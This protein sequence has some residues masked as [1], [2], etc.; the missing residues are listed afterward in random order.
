MLTT[1]L[2]ALCALSLSITSV[3]ARTDTTDRYL[4]DGNVITN[5]DGSQLAG[6]T[7]LEYIIQSGY[8][9]QNVVRVHNI[10]TSDYQHPVGDEVKVIGIGSFS[11]EPTIRIRATSGVDVDRDIVYVIDG[12]VISREEFI[13]IN[14]SDIASME[15]IKETANEIRKKYTDRD[16]VGVLIITT[17]KQI[18]KKATNK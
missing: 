17:K 3:S 10:T 2:S 12:R 5:F 7:I 14:P 15:V 16:D 11:G 13:K 4:I 8:D 9:R 1:I 18:K 6:K